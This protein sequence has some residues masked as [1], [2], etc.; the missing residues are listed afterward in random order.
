MKDKYLSIWRLS[1]P[2]KHYLLHP[3][4][5][6]KEWSWN[7]KSAYDRTTKGFTCVD[8]MNYD[9]WFLHVTALMLREMALHSHCY[10][11]SEPFET[12]EKWT[13]WLHRMADQ[14]TYLQEE[15][16]GNEYAKPYL[17]QLMKSP[18]NV[19]FG[20]E[21]PEEAELRT[22]YYRR[23]KEVYEEHKQLFQKTMKELLEHWDCLWD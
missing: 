20:D 5:L 1:F 4:R 15:D 23:S 19:L 10:P 21:T 3:L 16:N 18:H 12:P 8:W 6:F 7:L 14:L 11:G 22:K 9:T 17:D 2:K 13:S